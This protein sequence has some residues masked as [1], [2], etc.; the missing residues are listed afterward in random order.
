M[1]QAHAYR[2]S[3][4]CWS[5]RPPA[6]RSL[7]G[8][9]CSCQTC[10]VAVSGVQCEML[11]CVKHMHTISTRTCHPHCRQSRTCLRR[12]GWP[13]PWSRYM[14]C[15][16]QTHGLL[17]SCASMHAWHPAPAAG[18]LATHQP[19]FTTHATSEVEPVSS[20]VKPEGQLVHGSRCIPVL[21]VPTSHGSTSVS[22][23]NPNPGAT[24]QASTL[25]KQGGANIAAACQVCAACI[26]QQ[27]HTQQRT[28][29]PGS[30]CHQQAARL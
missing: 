2:R 12:M 29:T 10:D 6:L 26:S 25:C 27:P 20:V 3:H 18:R 4:R 17:R 15:T 24:M 21:K 16:H 23:S 19:G 13:A 22:A 7:Q 14:P 8:S 30:R 1:H 11:Q 5:L 28:V 9:C